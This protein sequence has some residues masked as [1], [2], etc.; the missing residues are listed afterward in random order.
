MEVNTLN[1]DIFALDAKVANSIKNSNKLKFAV[2][3]FVVCTI[4]I[5][6][7]VYKI[8]IY[9][10][11][12]YLGTE[13][14]QWR[15]FELNNKFSKLP[16][17][18]QYNKKYLVGTFN[19]L[20]CGSCYI[21]SACNMLTDRLS[22]TTNGSLRPLLSYQYL[23][24]NDSGDT[25][26]PCGG[27]NPEDILDFIEVYGTILEKYMPYKQI[28]SKITDDKCV[29][30]SSKALESYNKLFIKPNSKKELCVGK[31]T[32]GSDIHK[33]N[34]EN[35]KWE[36]VNHGPIVGTIYVHNDLYKYKKGDVYSKSNG[37]KFLYGHA[38]EIIGYC[39]DGK[40][41]PRWIIHNS[42]SNKFGDEGYA[43]I[44][45][46][47]NECNIESRASSAIPMISTEFVKKLSGSPLSGNEAIYNFYY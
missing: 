33:K 16:K 20:K 34:I 13:Y 7:I 4:I 40:S 25:N 39:D 47:T 22:L 26:D 23:L 28:N 38:V 9:K 10:N 15:I 43:L 44:R 31:F 17:Y 14:G 2:L 45:M 29:L 35:M 19:Q 8:Y 18:F 3:C 30:S 6:M 24:C 36:I 21:I 1:N 37:S 11:P 5:G 41:T 42:W 12:L 27:G 32:L 46:Y